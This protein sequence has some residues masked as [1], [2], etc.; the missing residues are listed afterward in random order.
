MCFSF[1][2]EYDLNVD[3]LE[4]NAPKMED[5]AKGRPLD[6]RNEYH[7][8]WL[9][10]QLDI[11]C[12]VVT[13]TDYINQYVIDE[14]K[15]ISVEKSIPLY[16]VD[17]EAEDANCIFLRY[18]DG[19]EQMVR[20]VIEYHGA[21]KVNMLAGF[22]GNSFSEERIDVYKK[23]L[24]DNGIEFEEDRLAYG[25]FW[26]R[27]AR[28][29]MEKFLSAEDG[30]PDAIICA[31]DG[32][33]LT[34]CDV[35]E[36]RGYKVPDDVIVTG[37]DGIS[38]AKFHDPILATCEPDFT[39]VAN[40][41]MN[42][43]IHLYSPGVKDK[44]SYA[45]FN[46]GRYEIGF[47][48][49]P[50]E[51]CGCK[52]TKEQ[53]WNDKV[54]ILSSELNDCSWHNHEMSVMVLKF[55]KC[56][57]L[58]YIADMLPATMKLWNDRMKFIGVRKELLEDKEPSGDM[59]RMVQLMY[60][61][62][63]ELQAPVLHKGEN[64]EYDAT[65]VIPGFYD[66]LSQ[67]D[68]DMELFNVRVLFANNTVYGYSI[69]GFQNPISRDLQ[70]GDEFAD[71][72]SVAINLIINNRKVNSLNQSLMKISE[73][74]EFMAVH[75]YLTGIYNRRGFLMKV[76]EMVNNRDN[77]GK[78]IS[79]Y[80]IDM[81]GLKFINDNYGHGEGDFAI[82]AMARALSAY[83]G[84]SGICARYGGDEFAAVVISD[85]DEAVDGAEVRNRI[86]ELILN[87]DGVHAKNYEISASVGISTYEILGVVNLEDLIRIADERMYE[88]KAKRKKNRI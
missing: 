42:D 84:L 72:L 63:G 28:V 50:N 45:D 83:I 54:S 79:Y 33:A 49:V 41:V 5:I 60:N 52:S 14:I 87:V 40:L 3:F 31:N 67:D 46:S 73:E 4:T 85:G 74:N 24:A 30:L 66:Y 81:D 58:N 68:L 13:P 57:D 37:F 12:I 39:E 15:K 18:G 36:K 77:I 65:E 51:S 21:R 48:S 27:P 69:D 80:S 64:L 29:A 56:D 26:D 38:M 61:K 76:N 11:C 2:I 70:R 44:L 75:D 86:N 25:N 22:K 34:A 10:R 43:L 53:G 6:T 17:R 32:M 23:V 8:L 88:D 78:Y 1:S 82:I 9:L 20:H 59:G 71:F 19:F 55:L 16:F 62:G 35:L 7:L 47:K